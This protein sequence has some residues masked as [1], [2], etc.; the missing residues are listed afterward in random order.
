MKLKIGLVGAGRGASY[1]HGFRAV[2]DCEVTAVCD[3]DPERAAKT[4]AVHGVEHL[5]TDY[6]QMLDSGVVN[7]VVLGTPQNLHAPQAAL[8]LRRDIHVISEVPAATDLM[9]CC[10]LVDAVRASK[11]T[12]ML[13]ENYTYMLPNV[14][15]RQMAAAGVFGTLYFAEGEYIHEL[16][17][18]NEITP[19]RRRWQTGRNGITYPTH[20][21]GP[22]MQWLGERIVSVSCLGSGHHYTD[23]RGELYEQEDTTLMLCK[24]EKG[25]LIKVRLDMLS[26]RPHN[27]TYY[28]L[29]GTEGCY[30]AARGLG[31]QPKVW[32]KG[33]CPDAQSWRPL[34]EFADEFLPD[35]W[36]HPP[37][38]A[39]QAGHGG[40]DYWQ[41]RDFARA[42]IEGR[43]PEMDVYFALDITV[44]GLISE[45]SI[46]L[47]GAPVRV[48]NFRE[49]VT[50]SNVIPVR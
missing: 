5:F 28:S 20:S 4:A 14:L 44:P 23:P 49:Y 47:N 29:Q 17:E 42:V 37:E 25:S 13:A 15:V 45:Q 41:A 38:E 36:K 10:Q 21:L 19:W 46:A 40:G 31:D 11:A 9:Q 1:I 30:E 33:R 43:P 48:P 27:M 7:A 22:V 34:M 24:T 26:E 32:I 8:A 6:E 39:A 3:L 18:L 12:Y 35:E 2:T 50:G 16:K